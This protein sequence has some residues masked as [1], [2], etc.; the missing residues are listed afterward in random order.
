MALRRDSMWDNPA[1]DEVNPAV[2]DCMAL[3]EEFF[4]LSTTSIAELPYQRLAIA[5]AVLSIPCPENMKGKWASPIC[6]APGK[7]TTSNNGFQT[8]GRRYHVC[9]TF[10]FL[11][12]TNLYGD[13]SNRTNEETTNFNYSNAPLGVMRESGR[14][15]TVDVSLCNLFCIDMV[16]SATGVRFVV[17][18]QFQ[19][20]W[21]LTRQVYS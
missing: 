14:N 16:C 12:E 19:N 7:N 21:Q 8:C 20:T 9:F 11:T 10:L 17:L 2:D 5:A 1:G 6:Y 18:Q 15:K 3:Q 4:R 13:N